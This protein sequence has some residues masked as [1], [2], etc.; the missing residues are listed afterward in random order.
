M[1]SVAIVGAGFSGLCMAL[2]LKRAGRGKFTVFEKAGDIGGTWRDNTYPGCGCDVP[3]QLYSYS[4]EKYTSWSRRYPGQPEILGYLRSL[5]DKHGLRPHIRL[6][7]E[8]T[9]ARYDEGGARWE[10]LTAD[11]RREF[12]DVVVFGVGQLN[13]PRLPDIPGREEFA[14]TAFHSARWDHG[15]DLTGKRVAVIGNGS[16]AAQLIAPVARQAGRLEVFQ[17]TPN[18]VLPKA[19][20]EFHRA[21]R[22][23]LRW[24]RPLQKAYRS[25]IYLR[26]ESLLYPALKNGWSA[27]LVRRMA[28]RHLR[29]QIDDPRLRAKLTPDYPVGCKRIVIDSTFYPALNR[30]DVDVVTERITRITRTGVETADG[31][32]HPADTVVYATGF[33]TTRFLAPVEVY[34]RDGRLLREEWKD[35]PEAY[36]G[37]AMPNFPNLFFLYGPNTNLGHNSIV[38]MI[39]C[40]VG[41]VLACLRALSAHCARSGRAGI[42]IR[43][44]A[45]AAYRARLERALHD[46]VW[47]AGC[48]S[49]YK[50]AAGRVT[51]NWPMSTVRYRRLLRTPHPRAFRFTP[52]RA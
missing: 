1:Q 9:R 33:E 43:P 31:L 45:M 50:N 49:W 26:A 37:V 3:S 6:N 38:L 13:R 39:E 21:T 34:G 25:L 44:E 4:F 42:E 20:A 41:Y 35:G 2:Q 16:S 19:D 10:V 40:Q 27:P 14:G 47:E 51:N 52:A 28:L 17:R 8:V 11:G 46:T 23:G 48:D 12:F 15:H 22:L 7:T 24:L 32:E 36:L 18:W 30:P 5:V 29:Q